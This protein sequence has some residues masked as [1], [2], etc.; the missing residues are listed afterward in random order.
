[1]RE[2]EDFLSTQEH[3]RAYGKLNLYLDVLDKRPNGFHDIITLFQ[4]IEIHDDIYLVEN[5]GQDHIFKVFYEKQIPFKPELKWNEKNSMFRVLRAIE[6]YT[7]KKIKGYDITL[8]KRLPPE[9]GL[10][11]ASSDA[12]ELIKYFSTKYDIPFEDMLE[13]AE[14]IGSDVPFFLYGNTA[15]GRGRGD[16]I[17]PL[18]PLPPYPVIVCQPSVTFSTQKMYSIID[19]LR[20]EDWDNVED[21][22]HVTDFD[23]DHEDEV[24]NDPVLDD[25]EDE[26]VESWVPEEELYRTYDALKEGE[27]T[28]TFNDFEKAAEDLELPNYNAFVEKFMDIKCEDTI[29]KGMTGS[30]SAH[31][32][33]FNNNINPDTLEAMA[34]NLKEMTLWVKK[35]NFY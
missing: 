35:T 33:V 26:D 8:K 23:D 6:K 5:G 27:T 19:S 17:K 31:F 24:I 34:N 20:F 3:L 11:G 10:G 2:C 32:I 7:G 1:M 30:G 15:L 21:V 22:E 18:D 16:K 4:R 25:W 13:I 29:L 28:L 9:S 14:Q 12:A